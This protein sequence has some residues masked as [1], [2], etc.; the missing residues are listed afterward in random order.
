ML[1]GTLR[2]VW[3]T[4]VA[5]QVFRSS[6]G[7]ALADEITSSGDNAEEP[8][9]NVLL[10]L[11]I[12]YGVVTGVVLAI[13]MVCAAVPF[14]CQRCCCQR[15]EDGERAT[16][17]AGIVNAE[18]GATTP[19][20]G[21]HGDDNSC[22]IKEVACVLCVTLCWP[23][24]VLAALCTA[25][26]EVGAASQRCMAA[27]RQRGHTGGGEA[28]FDRSSTAIPDPGSSIVRDTRNNFGMSAVLTDGLGVI[29]PALTT[30]N[31]TF[32]GIRSGSGV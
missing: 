7:V 23:V 19:A 4:V 29:T 12:F 21:L 11:L 1:P 24:V 20:A 9:N 16:D 3:A 28:A 32:V 17:H 6:R 14:L 30:A 13:V 22:H 5:S 26:I 25:L 10:T 2:L 27:R 18:G 15:E 8:K 31:S